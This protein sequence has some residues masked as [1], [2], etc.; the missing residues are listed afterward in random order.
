MNHLVKRNTMTSQ[1][2]II[3]AGIAGLEAARLLQKNGIKTIILE[4]RNRTGGRI[5]SIRT[6]N[7]HIFDM[8]AS[9]IHGIHG[10][11]P[12]GLLTNPIWDLTQEAQIR[13]HPRDQTKFLGSYLVED[14]ISVIRSWYRE[15]LRF[16]RE[17][18]RSSMMANISLGYYA[19][20]FAEQKNF[21]EQQRYA[22]INYLHF[23][24]G[25]Y[26]G[27]EIDTIGAKNYFNLNSLH[28]GDEHVF[29]E[30]G[31][32]ALT[33]YLT[34]HVNDIRLEQIV[35]KIT[36]N[37]ESVEISTRD[38]QIYQTQFVLI[39]VPL[40][41]LKSRQIEFNPSLPLWKLNAIDR[42]GFG[43]YEKVF[44]L[45]DRMWWN[46]SDFSFVQTASEPTDLRYWGSSSK[47]N[48]KPAV[49]CVFAGQAATGL[50][51]QLTQNQIVE[52]IQITLQKLFR[53]TMIPL[54][55]DVY[56]TNWNNDS[57]SL[58]S[59]S[60]I[61]FEQQ[62]ED[63]FYLSEPIYN[64]LLFAGEATSTDT[65]GYTHGALLTARR[66]VTRLLHVYNLLPTKNPTNSRSNI[67]T[68]QTIFIIIINFFALHLYL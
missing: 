19:N 21:T 8:G 33:D 29:S 23:S 37:N 12:S 50:K 6:K 16:V 49:L 60:Y 36:Y 10:S 64:R 67:I 26:E 15:Y 59:Y 52:Y 3:G 30:T 1:V 45:Y 53:N 41:V 47:W 68:P 4:G 54:P 24:I 62:H 13:T 55:I 27:T 18:T 48:N 38:G 9:F 22:F 39:T 11:I 42:I 32:M 65:Y 31:F 34:K 56:M 5:W 57:F 25:T 20:L 17:E 7:G 44:L 40:G 58:G 51:L 35:T 14:N 66:E 46:T 28:Y 43:I 2:L 61:S 63:P